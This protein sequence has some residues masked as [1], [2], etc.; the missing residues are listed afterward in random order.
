MIQN[1]RLK[2]KRPD[3]PFSIIDLRS[4]SEVDTNSIWVSL[5][6][7]WK[8]SNATPLRARL[9]YLTDAGDYIVGL[10]AF[11]ELSSLAKI[12]ATG[13]VAWSVSTCWDIY[14]F[15]QNNLYT[16]IVH[17]K[18]HQKYHLTV[19]RLEDGAMI[20]A[21]ATHHLPSRCTSLD[22]LESTLTSNEQILVIKDHTGLYY[23]AEISTSRMVDIDVAW[24]YTHPLTTTVVT[25]PYS[26]DLIWAFL[27]QRETKRYEIYSCTLN[28]ANTPTHYSMALTQIVEV[29]GLWNPCG[30]DLVN[31]L[32]FVQRQSSSGESM[33]FGVAEFVPKTRES[34]EKTEK[35]VIPTEEVRRVGLVIPHEN[36]PEDPPASMSP[37]PDYSVII[38]GYYAYYDGARR[39]LTV[40]DFWPSW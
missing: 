23:T 10:G 7:L 28:L 38:D 31:G 37:R 11:P 20:S 14:A 34:D 8:S 29:G 12:T 24:S 5:R 13:T 2:L 4:G 32:I 6:P 30:I 39:T 25:Q 19:R 36:K 35:T 17:D 1:R 26:S 9:L 3:K 27:E 22:S 21:S 15:G 33:E 40:A 18:L 16:V